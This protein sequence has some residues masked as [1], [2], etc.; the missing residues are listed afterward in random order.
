MS[1]CRGEVEQQL[2]FLERQPAFSGGAYV[3]EEA[4]ERL[5]GW[6]DGRWREDNDIFQTR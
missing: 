3:T 6:L 1:L 5:L 4:I 2:I